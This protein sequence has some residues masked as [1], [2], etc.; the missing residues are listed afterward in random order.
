MI[1]TGYNKKLPFKF[2]TEKLC[3]KIAALVSKK[4]KHHLSNKCIPGYVLAQRDCKN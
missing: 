4:K 1:S 2:D 3:E